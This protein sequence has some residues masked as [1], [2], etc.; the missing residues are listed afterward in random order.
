MLRAGVRRTA[1]DNPWVRKDDITPALVAR[2][3]AEQFP[4]WARLPITP[5][6]LDGW[7]NTTFRLGDELSVRLPS[8]D[9]YV[10][11]I[12]KEHRWLPVL[13]PRLPLPIPEPV[14]KGDPGAGFPRPWSVY[15][16][17]AGEHATADRV[18]DL[19]RFASDLARFL[20]ALYRVEPTDGPPAGAHS[21]FRGCP[22]AT[23]DAETRAAIA[24]LGKEIDTAAATDVWN[25]ALAARWDGPAVWVHGDVTASNLLVRDGRLAAVVD[26]G[27]SAV[28]DPACDVVIAWTFFAGSSR[29]TFREQLPVDRGTWAR[30]RGWALWKALI[31][32]ADDVDGRAD[33]AAQRM[34]W[35]HSA[36]AVI[37]AVLAE[38]ER[39]G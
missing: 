9:A 33:R 4:Q 38:H 6:D 22:P 34:G 3:V 26:F 1:R 31:T 15:R 8:A 7:D 23:Y 32:V 39:L 35:R 13:A 20:A 30:G 29:E 18:S 11:Q 19:D 14:A 2:L 10:A 37:E 21:F 16:W 27:C 36:R 12:D 5:V 28:G 25:A 17:L 24:A